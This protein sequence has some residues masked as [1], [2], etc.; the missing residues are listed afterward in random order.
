VADLLVAHG[1]LSSSL[2]WLGRLPESLQH[3]EAVLDFPMPEHHDSYRLTYGSDPRVV[4][5][6]FAVLSLWLM[7][8]S[9]E[10]MS[11]YDA[12][13]ELAERLAHPFTTAIALTTAVTLQRSRHD[14]AAARDAAER[15][16]ALSR[17][18][19]FP[20]YEIIGS[21]NRSWALAEEGRADEVVADVLEKFAL[22]PRVLGE[23]ALALCCCPVATVCWHAGRPQE[24]L[25]ALAKGLETV[26]KN[27]ERAYE[28]EIHWRRG[29]L[30]LDLAERESAGEEAAGLRRDAERALYQAL[31]VACDRLQVPF[32]EGAGERLVR[33]LEPA[34]RRSEAAE[35]RRKVERLREE[36]CA[37][38]QAVLAEVDSSV[39][40]GRL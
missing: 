16:I 18:K 15:L 24:A 17:E 12:T 11:R 27:D 31:E 21:M 25:A 29:E 22:Y 30:L 5:A 14:V 7:G 36:A 34:G 20:N 32:A 26:Q 2:F 4:A 8:S 13:L 6:Q 23:V 38:V 9:G 33:C 35:V 39:S 1:A 10:A 19:G 28:A 40:A 37:R 3:A